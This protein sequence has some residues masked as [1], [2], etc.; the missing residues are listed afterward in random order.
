M[1]IKL[2]CP[3]KKCNAIQE[4]KS[5][6]VVGNCIL[7]TLKCGHSIVKPYV[8]SSESLVISNDGKEL[9]KFQYDGV[10][11]AEESGIRFLFADEMGL[12]KTP[13]VLAV[14]RRNPQ[15]FPVI[16]LVKASLKFQWN[17]EFVRWLGKDPKRIAQIVHGSSSK[18]LP[19]LDGY[20]IGLDLLK[21]LDLEQVIEQIKPKT[22]VIDEC[23]LIKNRDSARTKAVQMLCSGKII[24]QRKDTPDLEKR[25]RIAI[26]AKDLMQY[27]NVDLRF[28]LNFE[29]L[30][31]NVLGMTECKAIHENEGIITG[32]ITLSRKHAEND[33]EDEVIETILHEI[34]HAI[35]PGAGHSKIWRD[36]SLAIG[37]DGQAKA[38]CNGTIEPKTQ[39]EQPL[40]V[41]AASG[42]PIKNNASEYFPILNILDPRQFPSYADFERTYIGGVRTAYGLKPGG[43]R[44]YMLESFMQATKGILIRRERQEVMPDLPLVN[45]V[46][47]HTEMGEVVQKMYDKMMAKFTDAYEEMEAE[48]GW[49]NQSLRTNVLAYI[50]KMKHIAGIAQIDP[51]V[52]WVEEFLEDTDRKLCIFVH[53]KDVGEVLFRRLSERTPVFDAGVPVMFT[54]DLDAVAREKAKDDFCK[55]SSR[56]AILST[57]SSGEGLDGLQ[58]VCSDMIL[59]E[60]QWNPA[61][62]EQVEGRFSRFGATAKQINATYFLALGTIV[63]WLSEL[64][65]VKRQ[66]VKQTMTGEDLQINEAGLMKELAEVTMQR[67]RK[68]SLAS[69]T[70][71]K[72]KAL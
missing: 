35:T 24:H 39:L 4:E 37:G 15:C 16:I 62:E 55:G 25:K 59:L 60:R 6:S 45:R 29:E 19:G 38:W 46:F 41:L 67:G 47:F 13:Q 12:G 36:T 70:T 53:H 52:E 9:R 63:E 8:K 17:R 72:R 49:S 5:H 3:N 7:V 40:Y 22:I 71:A 56:I 14:L 20:I 23:Q 44:P 33:S 2:K 28:K 50:T 51:C 68:W 64:V 42:T 31:N 48:G 21:N 34:A 65:E 10:R 32:K 18:I 26:I 43:I 54:S 57:L 11:A 27:H 61:N 66:I 30:H 58:F 1:I 69:A